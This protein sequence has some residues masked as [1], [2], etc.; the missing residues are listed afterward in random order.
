VRPSNALIGLVRRADTA[1]FHMRIK[2]VVSCHGFTSFPEYYGGQFK[3]WTRRH[4]GASVPRERA[5][6]PCR[7]P[8]HMRPLTH[9]QA[10]HSGHITVADFRI[11]FKKP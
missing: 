4:K 7:E 6:A 1:A 2:T 3:G 10:M 11:P 8:F 9:R 5:G